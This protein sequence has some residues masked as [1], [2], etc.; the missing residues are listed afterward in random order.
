MT[1]AKLMQTV[2]TKYLLYFL[3]NFVYSHVK[4]ECKA[5][6]IRSF[7]DTCIQL[8]SSFQPAGNATDCECNIEVIQSF[9]LSVI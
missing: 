2:T 7:Y 6:Q 1:V 5:E 3:A 8:D 9:H 4:C